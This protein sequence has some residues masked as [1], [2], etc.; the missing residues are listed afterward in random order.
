MMFSTTS[1]IQNRYT[2]KSNSILVVALD[3]FKAISTSAMNL[4]TDSRFLI[5][6]LKISHGSIVSNLYKSSTLAFA[7]SKASLVTALSRPARI[8]ARLDA[9]SSIERSALLIAVVTAV[10]AFDS[11]LQNAFSF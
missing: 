1:L 11:K 5:N 4:S 6:N 3:S 8:W 2:T 10:E 7:K 9:S